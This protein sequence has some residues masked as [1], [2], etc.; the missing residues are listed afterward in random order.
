MTRRHARWSALAVVAIVVS[1]CGGTA[2]SPAPSTAPT[3]PA[4]AAASGAAPSPSDDAFATQWADLIAKAKAEGELVV[5]T[6]PE[7]VQDDGDWLNQFGKE[8]GIKVTVTGGATAD[9]TARITAERAQ[10]VYSV[11]IAGLGGSGTSNMLDAGFLDKLDP[12]LI[13]PEVTDRSVGFAIDHPVYTAENAVEICQYIAVQAEPNLISWWYNTEK[14]TQAEYDAVKSFN[15]LLGP[16]FKGRIVIGD[17]AS[18]E[19]NRDATTLWVALGKTW[20]DRFLSETTPTVVAYGDERTYADGLASGK[21]AIGMFPPGSGSL[22]DAADAGLP[23]KIWERT[24]AEGN[25]RSGIQ[26]LCVFKDRPHPAASQLFA[27]WALMKSGQTA[28]NAF[29]NRVD[30]AS[31][32]DDVPQGK[33]AENIWTAARDKSKT[34]ID[35]VNPEWLVKTKEMDEYLKAKYVE[36]GIVPGG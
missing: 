30:R 32:R 33:I 31:I 4:S 3:A 5:V 24:M 18:N 14:V 35:D 16:T 12:L 1:A 10:S 6:G 21:W 25:P 23:V 26:R 27:N 11:D 2:A 19:A 28:L 13:N 34:F 9:I 22:E 15:D 8:F 17:V 20:W 29:T 7:G 36:L